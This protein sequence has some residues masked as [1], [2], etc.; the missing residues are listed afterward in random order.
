[1]PDQP[2]PWHKC[3]W[4]SGVQ[5]SCPA[6]YS[7][8]RFVMYDDAKVIDNRECSECTCSA[9]VGGACVGTV[10]L[11]DDA[12]CGAEF[13]KQ[14]IA[15]YGKQ[16]T[17]IYPAGRAIGSK[18]ITD[19]AYVPGTC[20]PSGGEPIGEAHPDSADAV[21]FCCLSPLGDPFE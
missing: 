10:R 6:N 2:L 19:V 16:C 21:T 20:A 1:M 5:E 17:N 12:A 14:P 3:V 13:A 15:S 8:E 4:R 11:Y 7:A 18:A 9:P